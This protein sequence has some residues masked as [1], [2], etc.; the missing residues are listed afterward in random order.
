MPHLIN[1]LH[2]YKMLIPACKL[3]DSLYNGS[4]NK[5]VSVQKQDHYEARRFAMKVSQLLICAVIFMFIFG[6]GAKADNPNPD[7]VL[8]FQDEF[9][10]SSFDGKK[11]KWGHKWNKIEYMSRPAPDWRKHQSREDKLIEPG[12][13]KKTRFVRLKGVYGKF[14]SQS[15]QTGK[16]ETFAC[17]GI[18]TDKTFSF[19]YGYVEVRARFD[20]AKGVWPAIWLLPKSGGWPDGGEI[21]IMEHIN[22]Q[23]Q[24]WQTIHLLRNSGSGDASTTINPQPTIKD[25]TAWHTYG[26]EWAPGRITF[27]VDGK[28][29]GSFTK[30]GFTHWPFD[31]DV[32]F[33]LLIDQQIGGNWPG[34]ANPEQLKAKSVNFD[35]DYVHI[36]S[37]PQYKFTSPKK[38][39]S[40]QTPTKSK[41]KRTV[42]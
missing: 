11:L 31:K 16:Q 18:F 37:S 40:K 23:N 21:D 3:T 15:C 19:R 10:S 20:C 4:V 2:S 7:W 39:K 8:V 30:N 26:V 5:L 29:T 13:D 12:K 9:S 41:A 1:G 33:Y 17:G 6:S 14:K 32:E 35:I 24:V 38:K 28:K 42:K 27:Y 34:Q 22:H 36:Y 25:V